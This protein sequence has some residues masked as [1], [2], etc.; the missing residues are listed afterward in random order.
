MEPFRLEFRL[1]RRQRLGVELMPWLP[2]VAATLGFGVGGIY[3]ALNA[4]P[5]FLALLALPLAVY[6][7]LFRF[8]FEIAFCAGPPVQVSVGESSVEVTTSGRARTLP[9]DGIFQVFKAEGVWTVLHL[10]GSVLTIPADAVTDEQ[11][12]YL[13]SFAR[14]SVVQRG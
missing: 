6:P 14:R 1:S 5:G 10:D 4:S 12:G 9:L 13:R 2:A 3:L 7:G 11:I 8:A